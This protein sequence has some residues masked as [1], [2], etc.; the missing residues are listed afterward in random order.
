VPVATDPPFTA[1]RAESSLIKLKEI[2][3]EQAGAKGTERER[4][5]AVLQFDLSV[6]MK[7]AYLGGEEQI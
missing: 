3:A 6:G 1:I 5:L 4:F 2:R 7:I